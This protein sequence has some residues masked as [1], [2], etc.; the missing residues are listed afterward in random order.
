MYTPIGHERELETAREETIRVLGVHFGNDDLDV[1]ELDRRLALAVRAGSRAELADLVAGLPALGPLS[2]P[3]IYRDTTTQVAVSNDGPERGVIG[4][5]M[6][7]S[8]RKGRWFLPRLTKVMA[9]A[10]GVDLDLRNATLHPG[11]S[12][13][14]IFVLMGGVEILVPHGVRVE[15]MGLAVAGGFE[16][17][18]GDTADRDAPIIRLSGIAIMGGVD[19][20]HKTPNAK[21]LRK[22]EDRLNRAIKASRRR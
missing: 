19:A 6:G 7:G 1:D 4:A 13:I 2:A 14:E 3:A 11:V 15:S 22:F 5:F 16:S 18:A 12:E 10:G 9:V 21:A 17:S 8:V 20:K